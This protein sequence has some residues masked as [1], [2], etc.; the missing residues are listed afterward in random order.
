VYWKDDDKEKEFKATLSG[1]LIIILFYVIL[2][3]GIY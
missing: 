2:T 1:V 3:E